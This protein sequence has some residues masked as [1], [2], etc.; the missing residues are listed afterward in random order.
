MKCPNRPGKDRTSLIC[1]CPTCRE[2][3]ELTGSYH[4]RRANYR[5]SF[6]EVCTYCQIHM[7]Y[8]YYVTPKV[9][10]GDEGERTAA[11]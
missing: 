7:G 5:Q 10:R 9:K 4:V 3:F 1:L 6:K 2:N 11:D 8:D